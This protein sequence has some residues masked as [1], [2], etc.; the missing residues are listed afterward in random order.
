MQISSMFQPGKTV[1][2]VEVFPPKKNSSPEYIQSIY[3]AID[4]IQK[5]RPAFISVTYGA[6]GNPADESTCRIATT[7]KEKYNIEP[8]AHLTCLN[9]SKSDVVAVLKSFKA[10]NINNI[11]SDRSHVVL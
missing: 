4:E 10:H 7:I 8:L 1:F 11:K 6:G 9:S 5:L 3:S 2:S